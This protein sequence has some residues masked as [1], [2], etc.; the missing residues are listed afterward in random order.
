MAMRSEYTSKSWKG[1]PRTSQLSLV[2][3]FQIKSTIGPV[4]LVR[5]RNPWGKAEWEGAWS[6]KRGYETLCLDLSVCV[7]ILYM[8]IC[9]YIFFLEINTFIQQGYIKMIISESEC[10]FVLLQQL[11]LKY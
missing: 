11:N 5:I 2:C 7:C 10:I 6:D 9:I 1:N 3:V 4:E 8:Y